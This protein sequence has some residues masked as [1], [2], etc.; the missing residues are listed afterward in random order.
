MLNPPRTNA[1][2]CHR[3]WKSGGEGWISLIETANTSIIIHCTLLEHSCKTDCIGQYNVPQ[4][5]K[6]EV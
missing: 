2:I 1:E 3:K 6:K 4:L 5:Y